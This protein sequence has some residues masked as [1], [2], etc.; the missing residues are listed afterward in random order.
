L[1]R[2][3]FLI[4]SGKVGLVVRTTVGRPSFAPVAG[5]HCRRRSS[6]AH[7]NAI[8]RENALVGTDAWSIG[9]LPATIQGYLNP[10]SVRPG[11][12]LS[13][14]VDSAAAFDIEWYRL[15]W[16]GAA[17]GGSFGSTGGCPP[18]RAAVRSEI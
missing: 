2:R 3:E 16:Y 10:A 8:G 14:H 4:M 12:R 11:D 13:V 7:D 18:G 9:D 17:V 1:D 15:G 5:P 6:A